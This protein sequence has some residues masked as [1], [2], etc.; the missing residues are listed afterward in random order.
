MIDSSDTPFELVK[1]DGRWKV[2]DWGGYTEESHGV[3]SGGRVLLLGWN[4]WGS[5]N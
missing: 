1:E 5:P 4:L 2:C 3:I